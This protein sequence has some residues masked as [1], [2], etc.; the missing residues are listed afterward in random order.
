MELLWDLLIAPLQYQFMQRAFLA[1]VV[2]GVG[3]GVLGSI[4]ILRKLA[5]M[6]DAISHAVLPGVAIAYLLGIN[7]FIGATVTGVTTALG[8]GFI[9]ENSKIKEDSAIGIMFSAAFAIGILIISK[10]TTNIDLFHI[11]FGNVLGVSRTDLV[12]ISILG[13]LVIVLTI[14][15]FKELKLSSFDPIMAR[16]IGL[17]T[18]MIHYLLMLMLSFTVVASLQT[19]G[20]VLV[21]SMLITPGATAYLL[22]NNLSEMMV[23][24][25]VFGVLSA[26][27]G[28]YLSFH[29]NVASGAAIVVVATFFFILALLFSPQ[30]GLWV[31]R[32]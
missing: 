24:S 20:I 1:A 2:V 30:E 12:L 5:L 17:P 4:L 31:S 23:L 22:T 6:G 10:I 9:A 28:L 7:F 19:V 13:L 15:F 11:L 32:D 18:D 8:I 26:L 16:S 3:C 14:L 27:V 21:V 29:L 25:G